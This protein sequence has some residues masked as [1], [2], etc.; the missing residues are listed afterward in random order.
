MSYAIYSFIH[1]I[2]R[3]QKVSLLTKG[4]VNELISSESWNNVASL[5][6]E[7]GII[8]E[9]PASLEDFEFML[10]ARSLTLLEKIRNY[11][12]I[13]RVTYNIVDLYI[14]MLS[15]D[16][17]KNIIVSIVNGIGNA[18]GNKIRFF[19][20]Y[21]D[22]IPSTL[23]ELMNS[24]K[25]NIYAN[26]L[27]FAI[28]DAQGK[29]VSYL[30]SLLDIYFIKKL[31]EIIEGF[32]GDWKSLAENIICYYK[33]YYSISLAIKHKTVENTVCKIG[34]EILKD[35]SSSTSDTEILD[36]L[37]RTQYS[38][39]LNVNSTYE[40]LA[41]LYR[42]ARVNARKSSELVF[43]SSPFN[44]A[45]ALALAELIRLDTED[46]ISIANAKSLRLKEE[47]IKKMLSFE[48][49]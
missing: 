33:D 20:K 35:L 12:S 24:F 29:N 2:S 7:R 37:R 19:R 46:L 44:P 32:K 43:M 42:I 41:S 1:S 38:K 27:S 45:L 49:I 21:F 14:Y 30:L 6:K 26:A 11:F 18:N 34:T 15:L 39:M 13:F 31:S 10:K 16:E 8:E 9:Q 25:G 40:A 47:E 23:E 3:T 36:I 28:K 17:L 22:Q 5:L 4:L 48:I